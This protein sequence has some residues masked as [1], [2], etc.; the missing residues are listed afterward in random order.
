MSHIRN[1]VLACLFHCAMANATDCPAPP[2]STAASAICLAKLHVVKGE[3]FAWTLEYRAEELSDHWVVIYGPTDSN[4]RGGGGKLRVDKATG[5]VTF[6][7]G[8]R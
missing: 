8:Y 7:E 4:V 2:V 1:T 3:Q 6:V 5:Q